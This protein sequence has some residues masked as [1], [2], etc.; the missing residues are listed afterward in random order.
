[1]G[2]Q[3]TALCILVMFSAYL[4]PG[5]ATKLKIHDLVQSNQRGTSWPSGALNLN[6]SETAGCSKTGWS[7][8][9][10]DPFR[11][12]RAEVFAVLMRLKVG[13]PNQPLFK[14]TYQEPLNNWKAALR[15]IGLPTYAV[16]RQ[17]RHSG[18]SWDRLKQNRATMDIK[19]RGVGGCPIPA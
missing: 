11:L 9:R 15:K 17:L 16:P 13:V 3:T 14:I 7:E 8:R 12:P 6:P 19:L 1:M 10:I 2:L 4:R 5:E 18:A